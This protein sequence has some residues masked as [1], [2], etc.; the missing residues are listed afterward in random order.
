M[1]ALGES[2]PWTIASFLLLEKQFY[3]I[4]EVFFHPPDFLARY[5]NV[6]RIIVIRPLIIIMPSV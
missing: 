1:P 6:A 5:C 3:T 2:Y 4:I